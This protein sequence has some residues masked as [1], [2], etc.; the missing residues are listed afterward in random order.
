[1]TAQFTF[2]DGGERFPSN[3]G[4]YQPLGIKNSGGNSCSIDYISNYYMFFGPGPNGLIWTPSNNFSS[5]QFYFGNR[6]VVNSLST[7]IYYNFRNAN[8]NTQISLNLNTDGSI[9]VISNGTTLGRSTSNLIVPNTLI[10]LEVFA[11]ISAT[12]GAVKVFL[13]GSASPVINLDISGVNTAA[14]TSSLNVTNVYTQYAGTP[15]LF[16]RDFYI[17]DGTGSAPFDGPLGDVTCVL[18]E[19]NADVVANFSPIGNSQ[20]YQN[21]ETTNP[22]GSDYNSGTTAGQEDTFS[23]ATLSSNTNQVIG[24]KLYDYSFKSDAGARTLAKVMTSGSTTVTGTVNYL[25]GSPVVTEDLYTA[26]P[27]TG[28]AFTTTSTDNLIIGYKIIS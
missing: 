22:N 5:S 28:L 25:N 21:I 17:H 9:S 15:Y 16:Q 1:M 19:P 27:N 12:V 23:V 18:I 20:N 8:N 2:L 11:V 7:T 24:I 14:D 4:Y 6:M 13:N 10:Y 3:P 26:D